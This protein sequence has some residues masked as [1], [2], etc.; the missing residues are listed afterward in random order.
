MESILQLNDLV[1]I[2][3]INPFKRGIDNC[4]QLVKKNFTITYEKDTATRLDESQFGYQSYHF[5]I[6]L[7]ENW[8]HTPTLQGLDEYS[9]EVQIRTTAQH[10]WAVA[11]QEL[12]YKKEK[13]VPPALRRSVYRVSAL[14]ETVDL[15]FERVLSEREQYKKGFSSEIPE[16]VLNVDLLKRILDQYLPTDNRYI[17]EPYSELL[18]NLS[19]C[20]IET[21]SQLISLIKENLN[22]VLYDDMEEVKKIRMLTPQQQDLFYSEEELDRVVLGVWFNHCGMIRHILTNKFGN[23]W[24][25]INESDWAKVEI[26]NKKP[27]NNNK[28]KPSNQ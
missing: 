17:D 6:K 22:G 26:V 27:K 21:S 14:L 9:A 2:R 18:E 1:G 23:R 13:S 7:P 28:D 11:S 25:S 19:R 15:E 20:N 5:V 3:L 16:R 24:K 8:K 4:I 10:I 12:Q